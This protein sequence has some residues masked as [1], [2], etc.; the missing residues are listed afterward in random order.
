MCSHRHCPLLAPPLVLL[1]LVLPVLALFFGGSGVG[2]FADGLGTGVGFSILAGEG[3]GDKSFSAAAT[4]TAEII[5][6]LRINAIG[7]ENDSLGYVA[8]AEKSAR[9]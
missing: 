8:Q 3:D 4:T 2:A 7:A 6:M 1:R 5:K 9:C